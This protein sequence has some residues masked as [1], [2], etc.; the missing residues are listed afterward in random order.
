MR[1]AGAALILLVSATA[2]AADPAPT[3]APLDSIATAKSDIAEIRSTTNQADAGSAIPKLDM[4]DVGSV[5]VATRQDMAALLNPDGE[6][7]A[8]GLKKKKEGTGNWLVDAMDK[9]RESTSPSRPKEKDDLIKTDLDLLHGD[10]H[11]GSHP[12]PA[13]AAADVGR[14]KA[15]SEPPPAVYNPL[16]AFM[17]GWISAKDHDLLL[18]STKSEGA[19]ADAAK[20]HPEALAG[21][22]LTASSAAPEGFT[23]PA[24][25]AVPGDAKTA[26]NPYLADLSF[27]PVAQIK[28][29]SAPDLPAFPSGD[30]SDAPRGAVVSGI[31][32]TPIDTSK[33]FI[34]DF[35]Q[36]SDDDKYF[37]QMK[38]F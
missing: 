19:S 26:A 6:L 28:T 24:D 7:G 11:G 20:A 12:E 16:D 38:H 22:D 9:Q 10:D 32:P 18:P 27:E 25:T 21:I 4:S 35:A 29:F 31:D 13:P 5:P 36:P 33:S 15:A 34:P 1:T 17:S 14:D 2:W 23:P 37:K 3:P 8:D 30:L